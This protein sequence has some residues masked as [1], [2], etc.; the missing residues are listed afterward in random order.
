MHVGGCKAQEWEEN[1]FHSRVE[2]RRQLVDTLQKKEKKN[3]DDRKWLRE[4][5]PCCFLTELFLAPPSLFYIRV[6]L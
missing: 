2:R 4:M 3:D 6:S 1:N 5:C